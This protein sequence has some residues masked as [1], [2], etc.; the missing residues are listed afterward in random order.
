LEKPKI[1]KAT[2][3]FVLLGTI[4]SSWLIA[5]IGVNY[6]RMELGALANAFIPPM[7]GVSSIIIFLLVDWI[8]PKTRLVTT[9]ILTIINIAIAIDIRVE[10]GCCN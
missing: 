6:D 5:N 2:S 3:I 9:V 10:S 4:V 7:L 1:S 8:A